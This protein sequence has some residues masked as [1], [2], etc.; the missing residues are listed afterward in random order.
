M[1]SS[2]INREAS[3]LVPTEWR[4]QTGTFVSFRNCGTGLKVKMAVAKLSVLLTPRLT[5]DPT[6][7]A[8]FC[9]LFWVYQLMYFPIPPPCIWSLEHAC[10]SQPMTWEFLYNLYKFLYLVWIGEITED[11]FTRSC[12]EDDSLLVQSYVAWDCNITT[13]I[14]LSI[15]PCNW[16]PTFLWIIAGK[17]L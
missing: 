14:E 7:W 15:F 6:I 9:V 16:T 10:G 17:R 5:T 1:I 11:P 8:K 3:W 13:C 4:P 2:A 12:V